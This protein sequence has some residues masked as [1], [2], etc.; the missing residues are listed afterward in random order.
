MF[1]SRKHHQDGFTL[2]ELLI[3]VLIIA[4]LLAIAI[5]TFIGSIQRAQDRGAQTHVRHALT[6]ELAIY[7]DNEHFTAVSAT[8]TATE[9][10]LVYVAGVPA[11][12][13]SQVYVATNGAADEVVLGAQGSAGRC[14]W[15]RES[16]PG[17]SAGLRWNTSTD[18][19]A[20]PAVDDAG[21]TM[22]DPP[23]SG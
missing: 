14:F 9:P 3:V 5:P 17:G 20:P 15:V 7:T 11:K 13:T 10:R 2:V 1:A 4:I 21:F 16:V 6:A 8:L 23:A 22:Q 18:C 12:A 19:S